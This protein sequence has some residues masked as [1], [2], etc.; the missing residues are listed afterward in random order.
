[1]TFPS[2]VRISTARFR[3]LSSVSVSRGKAKV[4]QSG[5][6]WCWVLAAAGFCG[7]F[8]VLPPLAEAVTSPA[9]NSFQDL[10][11]PCPPQPV[12]H[13]PPDP[14]PANTQNPPPPTPP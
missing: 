14:S 2:W 10:P 11:A 5:S 3:Q 13:G 6:Q 8:G 7:F 1:M 12:P 4:V 9:H